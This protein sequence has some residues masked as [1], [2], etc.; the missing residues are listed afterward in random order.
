MSD[1]PNPH[2]AIYLSPNQ[3]R[4]PGNGRQTTQS[5][6]PQAQWVPHQSDMALDAWGEAVRLLRERGVLEGRR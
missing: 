6:R 4:L 5:A 3:K 1:Q 2:K